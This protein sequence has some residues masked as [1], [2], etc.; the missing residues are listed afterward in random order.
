MLARCRVSTADGLEIVFDFNAANRLF[1][2][3]LQLE[4]L[5]VRLLHAFFSV[6][7]QLLVKPRVALNPCNTSRGFNGYILVQWTRPFACNGQP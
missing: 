7:E 4:Q 5:I 6:R 3:I 1:K 2:Q